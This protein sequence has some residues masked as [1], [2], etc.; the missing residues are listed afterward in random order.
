MQTETETETETETQKQKQKQKQKL[1]VV[2]HKHTYIFVQRYRHN[3]MRH[4]KILL[5]S[6]LS[7]GNYVGLLFADNNTRCMSVWSPVYAHATAI[8]LR[9]K[10]F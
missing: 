4:I 2:I 9:A 1:V 10:Y 6:L 5:T 7:V 3:P 8:M